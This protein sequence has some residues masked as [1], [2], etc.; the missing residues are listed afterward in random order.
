M[1]VVSILLTIS[2][3]AVAFYLWTK[4]H[5]LIHP[6]FIIS[7]LLF[8]SSLCVSVNNP[9]FKI[10]IGFLTYIVVV[11][12]VLFWLIGDIIAD[13]TVPSTNINYDYYPE[14]RI[15]KIGY[16]LGICISIL[17]TYHL[18]GNFV[19]VGQAL[20]GTNFISYFG[21]VRFYLT[22][23]QNGITSDS[24]NFGLSSLWSSINAIA[25]A[26]AF[27]SFL[28]YVYNYSFAKKKQNYLLVIFLVFVPSL[29]FNTSRAIFLQIFATLIVPGILIYYKKCGVRKQKKL[30]KVI[31]LLFVSFFFVFSL[32][33]L[34][35]SGFYEDSGYVQ[36]SFN[37]LT[38]YLGSPIIGIDYLLHSNYQISDYFARETCPIIYTL[39]GKFG[40]TFPKQ[41]FHFTTFPCGDDVSNVYTALRDPILDFGILGML[42]TRFFLGFIYGYVYRKVLYYTQASK[43][44]VFVLFGVVMFPIVFYFFADVF[45][46]LTNVDFFTTVIAL[47]LINRLFIRKCKDKVRTHAPNGVRGLCRHPMSQFSI[48]DK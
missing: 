47:F 12:S 4:Y 28:L 1:P 17:N 31:S 22:E 35:R 21:L 40:L 23:I 41:A 44:H 48:S 5:S 39:L 33:G 25:Q 2:L 19:R 32:I 24:Y 20:G 14:L 26:F 3:F 45:Y 27:V 10:D 6:L 18:Y 16:F 29:I 13:N 42:V 15:N 43:V 9:F 34:F 36:D 46:Y 37:S 38:K 30:I 8:L 7:A 11:L